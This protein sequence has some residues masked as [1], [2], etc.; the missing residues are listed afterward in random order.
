M[1]LEFVPDL[2]VSINVWSGKIPKQL[3]LN[4]NILKSSFKCDKPNCLTTHG[5]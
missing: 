4:D 5:T 2:M 3:K 1:I